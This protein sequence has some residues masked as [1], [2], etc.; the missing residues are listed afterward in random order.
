[1]KEKTEP[2][3]MD[4]SFTQLLTDLD[5]VNWFLTE[6]INP[7]HIHINPWGILKWPPAV[8]RLTAHFTWPGAWSDD[9]KEKSMIIHDWMSLLRPDVFALGIY[10]YIYTNV[11]YLLLLD[12]V[13][14]REED[15]KFCYVYKGA[16][17]AKQK[18]V[19]YVFGKGLK[20]NEHGFVEPRNYNAKEAYKGPT[21]YKVHGNVYFDLIFLKQGK[22]LD[23]DLCLKKIDPLPRLTCKMFNDVQV[24]SPLL[25]DVRDRAFTSLYPVHT[26]VISVACLK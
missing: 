7:I 14:E 23:S 4:T 16:A 12:A 3:N 21:A 6:Y 10:I 2:R 22:V 26:V 5:Q 24:L 9:L 1:M 19:Y 17:K 13:K 15:Y 11:P 25:N 18:K 8:T 20:T